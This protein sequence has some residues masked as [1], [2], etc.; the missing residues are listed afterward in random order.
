MWSSP[1]K[2]LID[3]SFGKAIVI[4]ICVFAAYVI[5]NFILMMANVTSEELIS[6]NLWGFNLAFPVISLVTMIYMSVKYSGIPSKSREMRQRLLKVNVVMAMWCLFRIISS[7]LFI[8]LADPAESSAIFDNYSSNN[9][10]VVV[11]ELLILIL[12]EIICILAV[13]DLG[14]ITIF[15]FEED[16]AQPEDDDRSMHSILVADDFADENDMHTTGSFIKVNYLNTSI[17][18]INKSDI[19]L[20]EEIPGSKFGKIYK[21]KYLSTEVA[22]TVITFNRISQYAAESFTDDI[23]HTKHTEV[24]HVLPIVGGFIE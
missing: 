6:Q 2:R 4:I 14:F 19:E 15:Q 1:N 23:E 21:S 3:S 17:Q 13:V 11:V 24:P 12:D 16:R 10:A 9:R 7:F 8:F 22:V 20:G 18:Q 5:L